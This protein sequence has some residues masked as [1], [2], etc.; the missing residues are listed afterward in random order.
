MA[1]STSGGSSGYEF[2]GDAPNVALDVAQR[3]AVAATSSG[4]SGASG[5][6]GGNFRT[7]VINPD[8]APTVGWGQAG[9]AINSIMDRKLQE[10]QKQ[11]FWDGVV[12]ARE[13]QAI[14]EIV[15]S[16]S[17][18]SKIFGPSA[19][20]QGA[21]FYKSQE[22]M[23]NYNQSLVENAEEFARLPKDQL[24]KRLNQE[25]S[26]YETGDPTTDALMH[27]MMVEQTATGLATVNKTRYALAQRDASVAYSSNF[28]SQAA[29]LQKIAALK[30]SGVVGDADIIAQKRLMV[31]AMKPPV[32]MNTETYQALLPRVAIAQADKGNFHAVN[33]ML[34]SGALDFMQPEARMKLEERIEK[35]GSQNAAQYRFSKAREYSDIIAATHAGAMTPQEAEARMK[36]IQDD[37]TAQTGNKQPLIPFKEAEGIFVS[38]RTAMWNAMKSNLTASQAAAKAAATQAEKD[39]ADARTAEQVGTSITLGLAGNLRAMGVPGEK[40]EASWQQ[41]VSQMAPEA[42]DRMLIDNYRNS[43]YV[44]QTTANS[45]QMVFRANTAGDYSPAA[46]QL[47]A[48]YKRMT[49]TPDGLATVAAY[50]EPDQLVRMQRFDTLRTSGL[51][52]AV[53]YKMAFHDPLTDA[54]DWTKTHGMDKEIVRVIK[55]NYTSWFPSDAALDD[56][57]QRLVANLINKQVG[58]ALQN[59]N[60]SP[61]QAARQTLHRL[62]AN[63]LET[64]GG[65]AWWREQNQRPLNELIIGPDGRKAREEGKDFNYNAVPPEAL[66]AMMGGYVKDQFKQHK[67]D[68]D[69]WQIFRLADVRGVAQ[70]V[71]QGYNKQGAPLPPIQFSSDDLSTA[72]ERNLKS[73]DYSPGMGPAN[74]FLT[75]ERSDA[76]AKAY[77][78]GWNK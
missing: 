13:G 26:K 57:S 70:L 3:Q 52:G 32:G 75:K 34:E 12:A 66:N 74:T 51:D 69:N 44:N 36:V 14:G 15:D 1:E 5:V 53:A 48:D 4:A 43:K 56:G 49:Q 45:M 41:A 59:T 23:A 76:A 24:G 9:Q 50:M 33:L 65:A 30:P 73:K 47:Y 18:L 27:Q 11:K 55:D 63:G 6:V 21:Q 28:D 31:E 77:A 67:L 37:Y 19:F 35:Q 8:V 60:L 25:A 20:V 17:P 64:F 39:A 78:Q 38:G 7:G 10:V 71:V 2:R 68:A 22:G 42:R 62:K 54:V 16:D 61:E 40:I 46:E 29:G 58:A 72:Y